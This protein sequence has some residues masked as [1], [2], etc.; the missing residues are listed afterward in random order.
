VV[1][2]DDE[3]PARRFIYEHPESGAVLHKSAPE[4]IL[5]SMKNLKIDHSV[6]VP[7]PWANLSLC[8]ENNEFLHETARQE[9]NLWWLCTVSP[10]HK[11]WCEEAE[12]CLKAGALGININPLWQGFAMNSPSMDELAA[13][14]AEKKS[15]LLIHIDYSFRLSPV[16]AAELFELARRH[17]QTRLVAA[18]LGGG[19]LGL[20]S[21]HEPVG[22]HLGN[23][24]YDTSVSTT[25]QT[26]KFYVEAGLEDR[27]FF[28]TDY[29]FN[30]GHTQREVLQGLK[31]LGLQEGV[32]QKILG[33]N[34]LDFIKKTPA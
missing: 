21:L 11:G 4:A 12:K 17:P 1:L 7:L 9:S 5:A 13:F 30:R 27:L 26:V 3:A 22:R 29:P 16:S 8:R 31:D 19:L 14:V 33:R 15:F 24:W 32:M 18:H 25:L 2:P 10:R 34:F 6:L 20:Y 28:G 23:V